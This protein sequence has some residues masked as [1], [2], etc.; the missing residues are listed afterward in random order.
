[1]KTL[2]KNRTAAE[3]IK[4]CK[5]I[6]IMLLISIALLVGVMIYDMIIG[7]PIDGSRCA[8]LCA[9]VCIL[10]ANIR[11]GKIAEERLAAENKES[12]EQD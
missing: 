10:S 8:I 11:N 5:A 6:N 7:E 4:L 3:Q 1:M 2:C 9:D 12:Q